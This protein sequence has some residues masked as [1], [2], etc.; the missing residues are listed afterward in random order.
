MYLFEFNLLSR[1]ISYDNW[2]QFFKHKIDTILSYL[3]L[4][5]FFSFSLSSFFSFLP[6]FPP[7]HCFSPILP[8]EQFSITPVG[9]DHCP[10]PFPPFILGLSF[11]LSYTSFRSQSQSCRQKQMSSNEKVRKKDW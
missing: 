10:P 11:N 1:N 7:R 8:H 5:L 3:F 4:L 9:S 2:T 6:S